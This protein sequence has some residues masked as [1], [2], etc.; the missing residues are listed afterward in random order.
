MLLIAFIHADEDAALIRQWGAR[1][2]LRFSK[3]LAEVHSDAHHFA[4]GT[5]LRTQRR[6][7]AREFR[8]REHR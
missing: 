1:A 4:R 6:I 5:H 8:E 2:Q 3:R 7:D